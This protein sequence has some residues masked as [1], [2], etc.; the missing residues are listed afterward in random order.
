MVKVLQFIGGLGFGGAQEF[1]MNLYRNMNRSSIQFDFAVFASEGSDY[2]SE[3]LLRG[4]YCIR[5]LNIQE[6]IMLNFVSGGTGFWK[7]IRNIK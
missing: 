6:S 3:I 2:A 7:H 4:G 5:Y 1:V